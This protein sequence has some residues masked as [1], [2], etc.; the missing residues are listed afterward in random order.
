MAFTTFSGPVRSNNGFAEPI[1]YISAADVV[2]GEVLIPAGG[3][4]VILSEADG[5]PDSQTTL[6]LPLVQTTDGGSFTIT[7]ADKKYAGIRGS[8]LNY[9]TSLTHI[10]IGFDGQ[11][12]NLSDTGVEIGPETIVQWGGNGNPDAPWAAITSDLAPAA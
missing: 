12:V 6:V 7:N 8:V 3:S 2:D 11:K 1:T 9:D 4:V 10:L 5:G